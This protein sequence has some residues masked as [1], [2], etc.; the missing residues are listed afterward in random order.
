M[1]K[2]SKTASKPA[3]KHTPKTASKSDTAKHF[4]VSLTTLQ[5]WERR[6]AP[7][8]PDGTFDLEEVELWKI[9][10]DMKNDHRILRELCQRPI[11][12]VIED[13]QAAQGKLSFYINAEHW[14]HPQRAEIKRHLLP[15]DKACV[16]LL[17][18][19]GCS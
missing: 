5:N 6:G 3:S 14:T 12:S 18:I 15:I 8:N 16:A 2:P 13:I 19:F 1:K 9:F 17:D 10:Q 11:G 7:I 4:R